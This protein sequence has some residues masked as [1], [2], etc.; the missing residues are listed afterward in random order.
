MTIFF[1]TN[2]LIA[3]C[4]TRG[5]RAD[6]FAHVLLE[7]GLVAGKVV[8]TEL[9]AKLRTKCTLPKKT[10]DDIE[11]LRRGSIDVKT[12]AKHLALGTSDPDDEWVV[13]R[14]PSLAVPMCS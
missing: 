7:H 9:R 12:P 8:L 13:A 6:R 1:D 10:I 4:A 5:L 14:R 2:V 3:A 11:A